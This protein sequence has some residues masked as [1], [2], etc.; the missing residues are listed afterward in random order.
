MAKTTPIVNDNS[1]YNYKQQQQFISQIIQPLIN[2]QLQNN[3]QTTHFP[4]TVTNV[5]ENSNYADVSLDYGNAPTILTKLNNKSNVLLNIDDI[6][7]VIA[8]NGNLSNAYINKSYNNIQSI[9]GENIIGVLTFGNKTNSN[10]EIIFYDSNT[11]KKAINIQ[12]YEM[13]F[14][15]YLGSELPVGAIASGRDTDE[16]GGYTG[17]PSMSIIAEQGSSVKLGLRND[18]GSWSGG[19]VV[20]NKAYNDIQD[21]T[22]HLYLN[23]LEGLNVKKYFGAT[24]DDTHGIYCQTDTDGSNQIFGNTNCEGYNWSGFNTISGNNLEISGS[25]NG[26]QNTIFGKRLLYAYEGAEYWYFDKIRCTT[27]EG[28]NIIYFDPIF[29]ECINTEI[30]YDILFIPDDTS[31]I[32]EIIE[33]NSDY[34]I[35]TSTKSIECTIKIEGKRKGYE[36]VRLEYANSLSNELDTNK[37]NRITNMI[38]TEQIEQDDDNINQL[39]NNYENENNNIIN[40][41]FNILQKINKKDK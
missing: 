4:G 28:E 30:F 14:Y 2:Q 35:F 33:R 24:V 36:N 16:S 8:P 22:F 25:K 3:K 27:V 29:K 6:V 38:L 17:S 41:L 11:G 20:N 40:D 34:F 1:N 13:N 39:L 18:D 26:I 37:D 23:A 32:F 12:N 9:A 15:D 21:A 19:L 31:C 7:D 10:G 5:Y